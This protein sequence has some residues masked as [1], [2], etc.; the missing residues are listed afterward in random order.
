MTITVEAGLTLEDLHVIL[1]S[2]DLG[3]SVLGS[4]SA[5]AIGGVVSTASHGTGMKFGVIST[6]IL[7]LSL[8]IT[9]GAI[10]HCSR[11]ENPEL[12]IA[13]LCGL[14]STGLILSV[15]L[16]C[17][18]QFRLEETVEAM[19]FERFVQDWESIAADGEH[20]RAMWVPQA[21]GVIVS[22]ANRTQKVRFLSNALHIECP[23]T[24]FSHSY[25]RS[26]R[27]TDL[28]FE[29]F[30]SAHTAWSSHW[31]SLDTSRL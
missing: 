13:T 9:S 12:F 22:R 3:M 14:G 11:A 23:L 15:Q 5:Q 20:V 25:S 17:E 19:G 18:R 2:H 4:I 29:A 24:S 6:Q 30:S 31:Q 7:S 1:A 27:Q 16:Q 26:P 8:L 28:G 10:L 21:K